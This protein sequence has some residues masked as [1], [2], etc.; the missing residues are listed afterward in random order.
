MKKNFFEKLNMILVNIIF[1]SIVFAVFS[2]FFLTRGLFFLFGLS[3]SLFLV[4]LAV[5]ILVYFFKKK[6]LEDKVKK[7]SFMSKGKDVYA[8]ESS[9][10]NFGLP[11]AFV[12]DS[13]YFIWC[14]ELFED[15]YEDKQIMKRELKDMFNLYIASK[16]ELLSDDFSFEQ[17]ING[18]EFLVKTAIVTHE[19]GK[20]DGFSVM[21]YLI[22]KTNEKNI[23]RLYNSQRIAV[24]EIVV[25]SYEEIYQTNG[26]IVIN[27]INVE[28]SKII[29]KW[30]AGKK[31]VAKKMV[32]DRYFIVMEYDSL[33][34]IIKDKFS[35]LSDVKKINVGNSIPVTLSIGVSAL[36]DSV[37]DNEANIPKAIESVTSRGGDQ[38]VVMIKDKKDEFY[39]AGNVEFE[40]LNEVKARV[41]ANQLKELILNSS[42]V[43]IMGHAIPDTDMD[44]LGACLAVYRAATLL[45][46]RARIVLKENKEMLKVML[47]DLKASKEYEDVF[48]TTSYALAIRDEKTLVVVVDVSDAP[49]SEAPRLLDGAERV[50]VIDHHRR[51]S[52]YIRNTLLDYNEV[53]ASST[54]ELM[55]EILRYMHPGLSIPKLEAEALYAGI[56]VDT[57]NL[58]FKTGRRTFAAAAFLRG[59]NVDT[60]TVRK[61]TQPD[62]DTFLEISNVTK[63]AKIFEDKIAISRVTDKISNSDL[64]ISIAAD[65]M[66][67][68]LGIEASF[69]LYQFDDGSVKITARSLGE[70]NVQVIMSRLGGG[71]HLTAA[72]TVIKNANSVD[73][74]EKMLTDQIR[75]Y[76]DT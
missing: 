34:E 49:R 75:A 59:E 42:K 46:K 26:E 7:I 56:L 44:S 15:L 52:A 43:I 76:L 41:V 4:F 73:S 71:G 32:R 3:A 67:N 55:V 5:N 24:G 60:V 13:G 1:S 61:Y 62:L 66:L 2:Y 29:D 69:V 10:H 28:L 21:V 48:I 22:D 18:K 33:Q 53:N 70:I 23:Q 6:L 30:L 25:D 39:G 19:S 16:I 14:N 17:N 58:V 51:G 63:N 20:N 12:S 11:L 54:S 9:V 36:W 57:K 40:S 64:V 38:A 8:G 37:S 74:V 45:G 68:V 27:S 31:A 65:Q 35:I 72:A 50:A 47:D